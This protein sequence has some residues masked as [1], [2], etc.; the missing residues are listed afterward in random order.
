M[1]LGGLNIKPLYDVENPGSRT[2]LV[3]EDLAKMGAQR[4]H[5]TAVPGADPAQLEREVLLS[6]DMMRHNAMIHFPLHAGRLRRWA[7][8]IAGTARILWYKIFR[9]RAAKREIE[10]RIALREA[11]NSPDGV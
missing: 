1:N 3:R 2:D 11:A 9:L 7:A 6:F 4:F 8:W 10:A 5:V